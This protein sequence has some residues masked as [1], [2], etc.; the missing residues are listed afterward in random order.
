M[1]II[2]HEVCE[3]HIMASLKIKIST[4]CLPILPSLTKENHR[5]V[6]FNRD[7]VIQLMEI[8][9]LEDI[10]NAGKMI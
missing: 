6:S 8:I 7:V 4:H 2:K 9:L 3:T 5:Q 1:S 10:M